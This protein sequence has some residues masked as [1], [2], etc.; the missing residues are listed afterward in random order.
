MRN[1]ENR[2]IKLLPEGLFNRKS[3]KASPIEIKL[4]H[5]SQLKNVANMHWS[6]F[7]TNRNQE[8]KK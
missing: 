3:I 6:L 2:A 7:A 1:I 5:P 8:K 4:F